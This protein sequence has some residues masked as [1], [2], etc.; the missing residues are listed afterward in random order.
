MKYFHI[1]MQNIPRSVHFVPQVD[2]FGSLV[3]NTDFTGVTTYTDKI[4]FCL[5]ISSPAPYA[6]EFFSNKEYHVKFPHLLIKVPGRSR[7][8]ISE[9][10]RKAFYI[11]YRTDELKA[12]PEK[13][14][15]ENDLP[16][17]LLGEKCIRNINLTARIMEL[18]EELSSLAEHSREP[19][20]AERIDMLSFMLL[21][22]FFLAPSVSGAEENFYE[23]KIRK[24]ASFLQRHFREKLSL[25]LLAQENAISL[26]TL[27]R[28][29]RE[30]YGDT[31]YEH[32]QN[33][34]LTE[35]CRLLETTDQPISV[36][37]ERSGFTDASYFVRFFKQKFSITPANYRRNNCKSHPKTIKTD[38]LSDF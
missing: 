27:F 9:K 3:N 2:S 26:R 17:E 30:I 32:L 5:R 20:N 19:G 12:L 28:Y 24:I 33:L 18:M 36:I 15:W 1:A 37:A 8:I 6:K 7:K 13:L 16:E 4:E 38:V 21:Q 14:S 23:E 31:P 11:I 22:E 29:W 25:K 10:G 34:R 35:G